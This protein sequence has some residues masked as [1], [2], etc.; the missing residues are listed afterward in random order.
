MRLWVI[1][2]VFL[3]MTGL[4][5]CEKNKPSEVPKDPVPLG[6]PGQSTEPPSGKK[7]QNP[8]PVTGPQEKIKKLP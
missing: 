3:L 6:K 4:T 1:G 5:G 7:A 8:G 2:V